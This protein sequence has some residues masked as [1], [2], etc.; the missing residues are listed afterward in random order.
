MDVNEDVVVVLVVVVRS[1]MTDAF[2]E[3]TH[4]IFVCVKEYVVLSQSAF[5][6]SDVC[7]TWF[8][9][10]FPSRDRKGIKSTSKLD[11]G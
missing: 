11:R 6:S 10:R 9:F 4:N 3:P 5:G 8:R 1:S 7:S 2:W